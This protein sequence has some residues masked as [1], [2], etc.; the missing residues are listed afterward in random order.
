MDAILE[1]CAGLDVHQ[2]TVVACVLFGPLEHKPKKEIRTFGTTTP[3]LLILADWLE[4]QKC[5]HVAMESTGIYWKP[6]WNILETSSFQLILANAQRIKNVPGRKTDVKDAEWIAQLLRSGLIEGSFVPPVEIRDLRDLTRYRKK[7]LQDVT[8]EKNRIHKV[9]QDANIKITTY[10]SDIFGVSGRNIMESL[11]DG[12][13]I[14]T[15]KLTKMVKGKVRSKVPGLVDALN[16]QLRSHHREMIRYSWEHL[17]FL[18]QTITHVE[19]RIDQCLSPYRQDI[20]L[21]NLIPGVNSTAASVMV[22]ELGTDMSVFP[23]DNHVSS[24]AGVSPGNNE[25]AGKKKEQEPHR[26]TKH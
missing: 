23:T 1:C 21:L 4:E 5:S 8:Q 2:E 12:E 25:S 18:E 16:H 14:T 24:W 20:E 3:E 6:V 7:L 26:G 19:M 22:A 11:I 17:G 10:I 13:V 15:E 9:L